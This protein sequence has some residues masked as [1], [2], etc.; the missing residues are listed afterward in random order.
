MVYYPQIRLDAERFIDY[1]IGVNV[2]DGDIIY[3]S[4]C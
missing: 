3:H 4:Y 2:S 1:V